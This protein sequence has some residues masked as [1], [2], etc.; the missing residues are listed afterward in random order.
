MSTGIWASLAFKSVSNN[1]LIVNPLSVCVNIQA[2]F[3]QQKYQVSFARRVIHIQI[4]VH[5]MNGIKH[6]IIR[7][8]Q[9]TNVRSY[10]LYKFWDNSIGH[11]FSALR[12]H[13]SPECKTLLDDLGG[14]YFLCRGLVHMKVRTY[15]FIHFDGKWPGSDI[16]LHKSICLICVLL[17]NKM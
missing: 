7:F 17:L 16:I 12:I 4:S 15:S 14:Y 6:Q 8:T 9:V 13:V 10:N 11:V 1:S 3:R 2:T 5:L